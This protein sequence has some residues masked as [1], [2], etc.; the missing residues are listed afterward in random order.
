MVLL[1]LVTVVVT[2]LDLGL[3]AIKMSQMALTL[4]VF[5]LMPLL[6]LQLLFLVRPLLA[7]KLVH[8]RIMLLL[9]LLFVLDL[10]TKMLLYV[11]H[12]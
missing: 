11:E 7:L 9:A 8:Q 10:V 5:P 12:M 4:Q 6:V 1:L 3:A 2:V